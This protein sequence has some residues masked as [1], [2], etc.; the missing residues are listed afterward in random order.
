MRQPYEPPD[1]VDLGSVRDLTQ[2]NFI[3]RTPDNLTVLQIGPI[4]IP[5][6]SYS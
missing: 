5:G 4:S 3:G 2:A 1:I 6:D